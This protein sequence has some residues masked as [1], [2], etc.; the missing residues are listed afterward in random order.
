MHT[1]IHERVEAAGR[2]ENPY[3]ICRMASGWAVL[4]DHQ[5]LSGYSLL[6]SDP[7]VDDLNDLPHEDRRQFLMDMAALGDAMLAITDAYRISYSI[8]GNKDPALHA[9]LHP[10]YESE[11]EAMKSRSV[12]AY[13]PE[14]R[15]SRPFDK[16]RDDPL[17]SAMRQYLAQRGSSTQTLI[18]N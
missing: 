10:R 11:P 4:A 5:F 12:W 17:I 3:V 15:A 14:D 9:H 2:G 6:L 13:S 18:W 7:V 1:L 8:L 16:E